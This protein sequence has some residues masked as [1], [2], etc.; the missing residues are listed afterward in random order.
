MGS[1]RDILRRML[2][3][4]SA[5]PAAA[6]RSA[7]SWPDLHGPDNSFRDLHGPDNTFRDLS[8]GE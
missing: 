8:G 7:N 3:W 5:G 1:W 6:V 2:G 4:F